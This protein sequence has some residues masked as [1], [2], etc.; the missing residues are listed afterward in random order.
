MVQIALSLS[1]NQH[2]FGTSRRRRLHVI[3]KRRYGRVTEP[4]HQVDFPECIGISDV[5]KLQRNWRIGRNMVTTAN[6]TVRPAPDEGANRE[7]LVELVTH[8]WNPAVAQR[9][10]A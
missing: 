1:E 5:N 4:S 6:L 7:L 10:K 9:L 2:A 3:Q 8:H